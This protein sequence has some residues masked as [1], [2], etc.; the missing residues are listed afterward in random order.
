V[1]KVTARFVKV[2][3]ITSW[4]RR[5]RTKRHRQIGNQE[6]AMKKIIL[7][8]AV[9]AAMLLTLAAGTAGIPTVH[10]QPAATG[11]SKAVGHSASLPPVW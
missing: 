6:I 4:Q 11:F 7:T 1:R 9:S 5:R 8:A 2:I 3:A 10:G